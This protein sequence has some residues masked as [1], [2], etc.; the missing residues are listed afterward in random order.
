MVVPPLYEYF[1]WFSFNYL[2]LCDKKGMKPKLPVNQPNPNLNILPSEMEGYIEPLPSFQS[3]G[4][5]E[6]FKICRTLKVHRQIRLV[7]LFA[8]P[9]AT[10]PFPRHILPIIPPG[11]WPALLI[12]FSFLV[13]DSLQTFL[14]SHFISILSWGIW[15]I[16]TTNTILYHPVKIVKDWY[17]THS[18]QYYFSAITKTEQIIN[19]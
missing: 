5:N 3:M 11:Q 15:T 6:S 9:K 19:W 17:H 1:E 13:Q 10:T 14:I 16:I 2:F 18:S 8:G 7:S 4:R 12:P